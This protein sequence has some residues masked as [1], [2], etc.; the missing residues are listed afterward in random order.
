MIKRE[1]SRQVRTLKYLR[2]RGSNATDRE[3]AD[4]LY[5]EIL[6]TLWKRHLMQTGETFYPPMQKELLIEFELLEE[7]EIA[8]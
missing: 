1:D 2:E 7:E 5:N 4:K 6:F 8:D 3:Y